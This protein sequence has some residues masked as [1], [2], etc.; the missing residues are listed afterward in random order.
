MRDP[1][2][3]KVI[4][5][6]RSQAENRQAQAV[7]AIRGA[8]QQ[9]LRERT[10]LEVARQSALNEAGATMRAQFDADEVRGY[11]QY[12]RHVAHLRDRKDAEIRDLRQR[13]TEELGKLEAATRS[14]RVAEKLHVRRHAAYRAHRRHMEQK[15]LDETATLYAARNAEPEP[16]TEPGSVSKWPN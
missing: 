7:A 14:R 5:R 13:E 6:I 10:G 11:Y 1:D 15:I 16:E 2:R 4:L 12:E 8:I 3:Y 9:A